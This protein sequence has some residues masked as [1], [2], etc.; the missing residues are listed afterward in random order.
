MVFKEVQRLPII[1]ALLSIVPGLIVLFL[2]YQN[3]LIPFGGEN[4]RS[5][6]SPGITWALAFTVFVIL[7]LPILFFNMKLTV[8][9]DPK[10]I[11][12]PFLPFHLIYC[13][14]K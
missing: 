13:L 4:D 14:V 1:F 6:Q 8:Q 2:F 7:T 9:I 11:H 10:G 12:Y 5:G 3:G